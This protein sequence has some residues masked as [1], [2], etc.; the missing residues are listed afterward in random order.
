MKNPDFFI[1]TSGSSPAVWRVTS[2]QPERIMTLQPGFSPY[3]L[4]YDPH[5]NLLAVGLANSASQHRLGKMMVLKPSEETGKAEIQVEKFVPES[6]LSLCLL[7]SGLL[8]CGTPGGMIR[9]WNLEKPDAEPVIIHAHNGYVLHITETAENRILSLGTDQIVKE[10]SLQSG[11]VLNEYPFVK[12]S[13]F[14]RELQYIGNHP[15]RNRLVVQYPSGMLCAIHPGSEEQTVQPITQS[16][17]SAFLAGQYVVLK[18]DGVGLSIRNLGSDEMSEESE[19]LPSVGVIAVS[20]NHFLLIRQDKKA[21]LWTVAPLEKVSILPLSEIRS[22]SL[23]RR[24]WYVEA[25]RENAEVRRRKLLSRSNEF[26][27]A[28]D[29][30]TMRAFCNELALLGLE[31]ESFVF[32][33][34]WCRRHGHTLWELE[35]R[36]NLCEQLDKCSEEEATHYVALGKLYERLNEPEAA[37]EAY[38]EALKRDEKIDGLARHVKKLEDIAG[39]IQQA[40]ELFRDYFPVPEAIISEK[41]KY[42]AMK[43]PWS[44]PLILA[45]KTKLLKAIS[46][47]KMADM[48]IDYLVK[49]DFNKKRVIFYRGGI[50]LISETVLEHQHTYGKEKLHIL[51][52]LKEKGGQFMAEYRVKI[53]PQIE[54]KPERQWALLDGALNRI[55]SGDFEEW[56]A[57]LTKKIDTLAEIIQKKT[58]PK[59]RKYK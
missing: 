19:V 57:S 24:Q 29:F 14:Q 18:P 8:A 10:W 4:E 35:A 15:E 41:Q 43:R 16:R 42:Q 56:F 59:T 22:A 33:A 12:S 45:Y 49:E 23:F 48:L 36:L 25:A 52:D 39:E 13:Q 55:N 38:H 51:L 7:R 1:G 9:V 3:A 47:Q 21:E 34:E 32:L 37:L 31:D 44:E 54:M 26:L 27:A 40:D 46:S 11:Q 2:T 58:K 28:T 5:R 50:K 17:S 30:E 20:E 53:S 6:V